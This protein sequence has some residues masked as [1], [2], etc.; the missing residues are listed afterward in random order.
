M[1]KLQAI[2]SLRASGYNQYVLKK[3]FS[4]PKGWMENR[5]QNHQEIR[6][7]IVNKL[8]T[9]GKVRVRKT[10]AGSYLFPEISDLKV[11]IDEFVDQLRTK[12]NVIVTPG[13]EF[14]AQFNKSFRIN[15]SQDKH[16][17]L[18]ATDRII[19]MIEEFEENEQ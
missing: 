17:A 9:S 7:E 3:W 5:I 19:K 12:A 2:V 10:E 6:D 8:R 13:T 15:F 11:S 1:E 4:E 18:D 16:K 14:G